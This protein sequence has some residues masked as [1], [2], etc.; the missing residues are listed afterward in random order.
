MGKWLTVPVVP[1]WLDVLKDDSL[2]N[3]RDLAA[4]FGYKHV[5]SFDGMV[6]AGRFP[7]PDCT[8]RSMA[9]GRT[10]K[11]MWYK[12]TILKEIERRNNEAH[13]RSKS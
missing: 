12:K 13:P 9:P 4:L 5:N 6:C 8:V 3:S 2:L 1:K 11:N 7:A 10:A